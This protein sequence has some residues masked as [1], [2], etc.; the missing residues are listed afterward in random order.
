MATNP[1]KRLWTVEEYLAHEEKTGIK[2]EYIDGEI[3]AMAGGSKNHGKIKSRVFIALGKQLETSG[4]CEIY[5]SDMRVKISKNKFVYP[6][7]TVVCGE[8][9]YEDED[10]AM[11]TNPTLLVEVISDSSANYDKGTK[12]DYYM[13]LSSVQAYLLLEQNRAFAKL[14][15]RDATGWHIEDYKGLEAIVPLEA[16]GCNLALS[17]AYL[18]VDFE[19][20]EE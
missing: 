6:D 16:I 5:D 12:A 11:L 8:E 13:S 10:N 17:E 7:I 14:Y 15:T 9:I 2:H 4:D 19:A 3:F 18:N 20:E 1:V